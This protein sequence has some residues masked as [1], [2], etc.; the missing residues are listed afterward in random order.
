LENLKD[1]FNHSLSVSSYTDFKYTNYLK[2]FNGLLDYIFYD[3]TQ[4]DLIKVLPMPEHSE[5]IEET[6]LPS[7][8]IPSDHLAVVLEL[9]WNK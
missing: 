6:A 7:R 2:I 4:F 8:K 3:K 5:V 9:K 1:S